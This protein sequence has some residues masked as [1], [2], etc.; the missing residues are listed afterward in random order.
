MHMEWIM[1]R[2]QPNDYVKAEI[3]DEA[4]K[5]SEWLRVPVDDCDERRQVIFGSVGNV[6]VVNTDLGLGQQLA[7]SYNK[8]RDH[9]KASDF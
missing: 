4:G 7:V 8:I 9:R 3:V 2:Y 5:Q 1:G 6:P